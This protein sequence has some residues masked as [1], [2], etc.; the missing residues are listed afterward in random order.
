M[1]SNYKIKVY[2]LEG[3]G[4]CKMLL[5]AL[6]SKKINYSIVDATAE[7]NKAECDRLED[8]FESSRYP[9]V[10]VEVKNKA[11]FINPFENKKLSPFGDNIFEY[12]TTI[13][14]IVATIKKYIKK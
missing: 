7:D 9:K 13:D 12:Y 11:I 10:I 2:K 6:D 1:E 4:F 8:F 14:E 3:C 5:D